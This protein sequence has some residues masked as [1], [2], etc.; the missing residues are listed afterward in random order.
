M[1][2]HARPARE[3]AP[4]T[5]APTHGTPAGAGTGDE[6]PARAASSPLLAGYRVLRRLGSGAR[7][8]VYLGH[9]GRGHEASPTDGAGRPAGVALKVFG[10]DTDAASIEREIRA[11]SQAP[12]GRLPELLDVATLPD[13]RVC[14]VL[15]RL[16]GPS[17]GRHLCSIDRLEPGEAVTILAP[18]VTALSELHDAGFAHEGLSPSAVLFDESRRP[19]VTG[20]GA[21]REL[22]PAGAARITALRSDYLRLGVLLRAVFDRL[23]PLDPTTPAAEQLASWFEDKAAEVPFH[24]CLND[25]ERRLFSLA[26]ATAVSS[27]DAGPASAAPRLPPARVPGTGRAASGSDPVA[28]DQVG[29]TPDPPERRRLPGWFAVFHLPPEIRA[30]LAGAL[31]ANPAT[32]GMARLRD[33]AGRRRRPLLLAALLAAALVLPALSLLPESADT[34]PAQQSVPQQPGAEAAGKGAQ[35]PPVAASDTAALVGDEPVLAVPVLLGLRAGCLAA[36]SIVCLD[37][38]DQPGSAIMAADS[39]GARSAQQGGG[40]PAAPTFEDYTASLIERTGN[41]ALV[42]LAPPDGPAGA[43]RRPASALVVKGEAGWRL[44]EIFDY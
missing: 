34:E 14:L 19:V 9:P 29:A 37:G 17:L 8:E 33:R 20:L 18:V 12:A 35:S 5:R 27:I 39:Y 1:R 13:G 15:E 40:A 26:P 6:D 23:D 3:P 41:S 31:A 11:L 32:D 43:E 10:A 21:L 24:P 25:L 36:A 7:A 22:P 4:S 16:A 30:A 44:R 42:A 28:R 38:V 2:K